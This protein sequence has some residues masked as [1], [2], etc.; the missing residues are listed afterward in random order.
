MESGPP[1]QAINRRA[2]RPISHRSRP[3]PTAFT[4]AGSRS[5]GISVGLGQVGHFRR[6][7][8]GQT[9]NA[10]AGDTVEFHFSYLEPQFAIAESRAQ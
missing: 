2:R 1:E 3:W 10:K 8:I 4:N 7:H 5:A 9:A 6:H